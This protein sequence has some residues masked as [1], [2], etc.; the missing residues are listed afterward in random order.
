MHKFYVSLTEIRYNE[1]SSRIEVSMRIF[2][3]D[4]DR[5]LEER[6]GVDTHLA[7]SLEPPEADS[8][9]GEYLRAHFSV[10]TDGREVAFTY[11]GKEPESDALWCYL[12]SE[13]LEATPPD[14][15]IRNNL[16]MDQ[17]EG[18]VNIIQVYAGDWNRGLLFTKQ[19][20]EGSLTIG[21]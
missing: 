3:D 21:D 9:V 16:L 1:T 14:L 6:Y 4:L 7:S 17:F 18:Q 2:P 11:L 5:A 20:P 15:L 12:E 19:S 10:I 8:L 13:P